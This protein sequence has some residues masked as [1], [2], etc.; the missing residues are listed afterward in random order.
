MLDL[1]ARDDLLDFIGLMASVNPCQFQ[2]DDLLR[3][4][5]YAGLRGSPVAKQ[6]AAAVD[7]PVVT[8]NKSVQMMLAMARKR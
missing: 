7:G 6:I 8:D 3:L 2:R 4:V 5:D 1:R